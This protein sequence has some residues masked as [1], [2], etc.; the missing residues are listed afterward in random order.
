[1][2]WVASRRMIQ[3]IH[4]T[5][6]YRRDCAV[7]DLSLTIRPRIVIG[8]L[9]PNGSGKSTTMR[10]I[11]DSMLRTSGDGRAR[12]F[13]A[14]RGPTGLSLRKAAQAAHLRLWDQEKGRLVT[15]H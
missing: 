14:A 13:F 12:W 11:S 15:F 9:G 6:D 2:R 3:A 4:L 7:G 1:M 5:K 10:L 8:L